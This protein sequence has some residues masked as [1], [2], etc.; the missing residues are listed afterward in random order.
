MICKNCGAELHGDEEFCTVCGAMVEKE[1]PTAE[2]K[3]EP[4]AEEKSEPVVEEKTE[5]VINT[6]P[7][8]KMNPEK[9]IGIIVGIVFIVIGFVIMGSGEEYSG[10]LRSAAFGADFYTYTYDGI[11]AVSEGIGKV[12]SNLCVIIKALGWLLVGLGAF[13]DCHFISKK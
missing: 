1:E 8:Q 2:E 9:I 3:A 6:K 7:A 11:V 13:M 10:Y 5:T 12:N 4:V